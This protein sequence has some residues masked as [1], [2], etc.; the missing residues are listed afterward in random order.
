VPPTS[1]Y[2]W[3][4]NAN[5]SAWS[6]GGNWVGGAAPTLNADVLFGDL[7]A[8]GPE[9]AVNVNNGSKTLRAL[10][11]DAGK[12]YT[13]SGANL[14]LGGG[15]T[16]GA[17]VITVNADWSGMSEININNNITFAVSTGSQT[18]TITN[19]SEGGLR[20]GGTVQLGTSTL[21][22]HLIVGGHG[23]THFA[24]NISG[25]G[26][27]LTQN[28]QTT[29]LVLSGNNANWQG[30]VGVN[31][32][33]LA[34]IKRN[35]ALPG[36]AGGGGVFANRAIVNGGT[37]GFRSHGHG[38]ALNY[39]SNHRIQVT[40][41]G[42]VRQWGM[43][44]VGAVYNDGGQNTF[45]GNIFMQGDTWF[46]SR[47][48]RNGGLTLT[49][50]ISGGSYSFTKV[51]PG[52][53]TLT[54]INNTWTGNTFL[55]G[56]V[57][58][59]GNQTNINKINV[60]N[61][62]IIFNGGILELN[63]IGRGILAQQ[64]WIQVWHFD[65]GASTDSGNRI[66]NWQGSGG[67]SAFG[68]VRALALGALLTVAVPPG[69]GVPSVTFEMLQWGVNNFVPI[70]KELLLSSRY[71]NAPITLVN[72]LNPGG[73]IIRVERG[74]NTNAYATV[75][76]Q[77][78]A[79]SGGTF[80]KRGLGRLHLSNNTNNYSAQTIIE[81]G[82]LGGTISPNSNIVLR[83]GVVMLGN[84][85]NANPT[86]FTR[87]VGPNPGQI[88]WDGGWF[89]QSTQQWVNG[90]GFA[91][92]SG[93]QTVRLNNSTL[94]INW[95]SFVLG[96]TPLKFGH[97]TA[98]G[99]VIWDKALDLGTYSD[100]IIVVERGR[101]PSRADVVFSQQITG[102]ASFRVEGDGRM[103]TQSIMANTGGFEIRGAELRLNKGGRIS[104]SNWL[105]ITHGG[106]LTLDNRGSYSSE[107]GGGGA[108]L[109]RLGSEVSLGIGDGGAFRLWGKSG[110][111]GVV[112]SIRHFRFYGDGA[113]T[114]DLM[115]F[116]NTSYTQLVLRSIVR[117]MHENFN[118]IP[119]LGS[120]STSTLNLTSNT[121]FSLGGNGTVSIRFTHWGEQIYE[122]LWGTKWHYAFH[123][124]NDHDSKGKIIPWATVNG[125]DWVYPLGEGGYTYLVALPEYYTGAPLNWEAEHNVSMNS[126][127]A[128]LEWNRE[129]N[130]LRLLNDSMIQLKAANLSLGSGGILSYKKSVIAG[131][132]QLSV[133]GNKFGFRRPF[134]VHVYGGGL[135]IE[136]E[137][138]IYDSRDFIKT[139]DGTLILNSL[140]QHVFGNLYIHEGTVS[141]R[142][143]NILYGS[144]LL[145][146]YSGTSVLELPANSWNSLAWK[147]SGISAIWMQGP[148]YG[149]GPEYG[150]HASILRMGG[151]TKQRLNRLTIMEGGHTVIDFFGGEVGKANILWIDELEF[152]QSSRLYIRNW[153]QYEDYLLVGKN[154]NSKWAAQ[155]IFEGYEDFPVLFIDY[156]ANYWQITP[157]HAPEPST[158]GAILGA[159]GL[160]LVTW[161][162]RKRKL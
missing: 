93:D 154:F 145:G 75:S 82:A 86:T 11:F 106:I 70:G 48:D 40:G 84:L 77:I 62:T 56:G 36:I 117:P 8:N 21:P 61:P 111:G 104:A 123:E 74:L 100:R 150:G 6:A 41:Q 22:A 139:G 69:G 83:G 52:L 10:W 107:T 94:L 2:Q 45:R 34:F 25:A 87:S 88:R 73:A 120:N 101:D 30:L 90:G 65:L 14:T 43:P 19:H 141:L 17:P 60:N 18:R 79:G 127:N 89:D 39:S 105:T 158:Y 124:I 115:N 148:H 7:P 121:E 3:S 119:T 146:D 72:G 112:E 125:R 1:A 144:I 50:Q 135:L 147:D 44:P 159:V 92:W 160:G 126:P 138:S 161:K 66:I 28:N 13:L 113:A 63:G 58:R 15:L 54:Y 68:S 142:R 140:T 85:N 42:A 132:G 130:S 49:G 99:T 95:D 24:N 128:I 116:S 109:G 9:V 37:L 152:D 143:G 131:T 153:Y 97:Y 38:P 102:A 78:T 129:V 133:A 32:E 31:S 91:A 98:S 59:V 103:D 80:T 81:Q 110:S 26:F 149:P 156:D 57:L 47:G 76:G 5:S 122:A 134:Y 53:I 136:G 51:G 23:A 29:H 67:F 151:N 157:F 137:V 55:N 16:D 27:I 35:D 12:W 118:G 46:G 96:F 162:R 155:I 114:V 71:A 33:S 64:P 20:L 4:G 108:L